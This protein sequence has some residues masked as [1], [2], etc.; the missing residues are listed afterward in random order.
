MWP[1][2]GKK[3]FNVANNRLWDER[4]AKCVRLAT[5]AKAFRLRQAFLSETPMGF[6]R[7]VFASVFCCSKQGVLWVFH[8]VLPHL[9]T[10]P[11]RKSTAGHSGDCALLC[12]CAK[13]SGAGSVYGRYL[14]LPAQYQTDIF[15][16]RWCIYRWI[17]YQCLWSVPQ[18]KDNFEFWG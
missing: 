10:S 14:P 2:Y 6:Y 11:N 7:Q 13:V 4:I 5:F 9:R 15:L 16:C 3:D 18:V 17:P 12:R 8:S 1:K